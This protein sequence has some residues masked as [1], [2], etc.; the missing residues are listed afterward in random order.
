MPGP[1]TFF[2]PRGDLRLTEEFSPTVPA[3]AP[4]ATALLLAAIVLVAIVAT[5]RPALSA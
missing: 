1:F 2:T 5:Q 4:V 3:L